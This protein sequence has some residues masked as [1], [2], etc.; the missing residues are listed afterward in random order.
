MAAF[1]E[2]YSTRAVNVKYYLVAGSLSPYSNILIFGDDD[3]VVGVS[4]VHGIF[5]RECTKI[6][7]TTGSARE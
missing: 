7:Q 4:S 5:W 6:Y 3:Y 2:T 1:N